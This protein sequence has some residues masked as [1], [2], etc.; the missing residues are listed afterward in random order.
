[1]LHTELEHGVDLVAV[2][3]APVGDRGAANEADLLSGVVLEAEPAD[4]GN[5]RRFKRSG[6]A[7]ARPRR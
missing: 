1:M 5:A 6:T 7:L 4:H 2:V 3:A